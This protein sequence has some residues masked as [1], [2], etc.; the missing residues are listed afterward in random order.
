MKIFITGIAGFVGSTL[1]ERL[2]REGHTIAGIDNLSTGVWDNIPDN[3]RWVEGDIIKMRGFEKLRDS[4]DAVVHTAAQ[5]SGEKSFDAPLYDLEANIKGSY[6]AFV[7][8]TS[9]NAK[10]FINFSSMSVYG[11]VPNQQMVRETYNPD[12]VSL[13][14]NSKLSA[15]R[16]L[17]LLSKRDKLPVISFRLFNAYGPKQNLEELKQGMVSIYLAQFLNNDC[18]KV[19][20]KGAFDRVRDFIYIDDIVDIV[21]KVLF[22]KQP[23]SGVYNLSSNQVTTVQTLIDYIKSKTRIQKEVISKGSTPGDIHGFGGNASLLSKTFN[24]KP[25]N[26]IKTGLAKMIKFYME[27][28]YNG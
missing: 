27:R 23:I 16:M 24:W 2:L 18:D 25:E 14:G 21:L 13:Y 9:C 4:Y 12:P 15:E 11:N 3:A 1:A 8:A 5:T 10:I 17:N 22:L 20:V 28:N 7:F 19:I 26:D 6:N